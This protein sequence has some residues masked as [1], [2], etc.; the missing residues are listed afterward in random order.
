MV[1]LPN[2]GTAA[3]P[4]PVA[5]GPSGPPT[6]SMLFGM[7][8]D[9]LDDPDKH[10]RILDTIRAV[11]QKPG[12]RTSEFMLSGLLSLAGGAMQFW[13]GHEAIGGYLM[14]GSTGLFLLS[15]TAIKVMALK[16][17]AAKASA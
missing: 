3:I 1:D 12:V 16:V 14:L 10:D 13:P 11:Q 6:M 17:D 9:A 4:A 8:T 7:L 5:Q 2:V 15:R